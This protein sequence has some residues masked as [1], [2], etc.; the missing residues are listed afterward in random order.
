MTGNNLAPNTPG[1]NS[2]DVLMVLTPS[3]RCAPER[4]FRNKVYA[5]YG[6]DVEPFFL[7]TAGVL[8]TPQL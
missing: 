4:R 8:V 2:P 3:I 5:T 7:H 1:K 6:Q